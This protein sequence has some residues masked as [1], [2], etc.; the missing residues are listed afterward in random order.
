MQK[1]KVEQ[2]HIRQISKSDA[3]LKSFSCVFNFGDEKFELPDFWPENDTVS[4]FC[5]KKAA[6]ERQRK[7]DHK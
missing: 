7:L 4:G 6:L 1:K 2:H 5:L 3:Y